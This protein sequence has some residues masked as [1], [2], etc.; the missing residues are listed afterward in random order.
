MMHR[1]KKTEKGRGRS[2]FKPG[3][4]IFGARSIASPDAEQQKQAGLCGPLCSLNLMDLPVQTKSEPNRTG[5]PDQLKAGI[6][7]LSGMDISD[8]RVH[9]NSDKPERLNALAYAQGSDIHL[10][11]G[12]GQH[13]PHEAW[14]LVQQRQGRVKPTLQAKGVEINDDPELEQ[15]ADRMGTKVGSWMPRGTMKLKEGPIFWPCEMRSPYGA[16]IRDYSIRSNHS[17]LQCN[18]TTFVFD[19][20]TYDL[21]KYQDRQK[22]LNNASRGMLKALDREIG[23]LRQGPQKGKLRA[24]R[25]E[26]LKKITPSRPRR[27]TQM[28]PAFHF[29]PPT[30]SGAVSY[31][32]NEKFRSTSTGASPLSVLRDKVR[33]EVLEPQL[34]KA[35]TAISDSENSFFLGLAQKREASGGNSMV[36]STQD[37]SGRTVQTIGFFDTDTART[38][39]NATPDA[40]GLTVGDDRG[41]GFPQYAV[42]NSEAADQ[43]KHMTA[44]NFLA[45]QGTTREVEELGVRLSRD[46]PKREV[47]KQRIYIYPLGDLRPAGYYERILQR[48]QSL[49]H[50]QQLLALLQSNPKVDRDGT[51]L[52]PAPDEATMRKML[53]DQLKPK[54]KTS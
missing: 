16:S 41:H 8:V 5:M 27:A 31:V 18:G 3:E 52:E 7:S 34:L 13:L 10:A 38:G 45:N 23:K 40:P 6:E 14:H 44:E 35:P 24:I 37:E 26:V 54:S 11:P 1:A 22:I 50:F 53:D 28:G 29:D 12:Q 9:A 51:L 36:V 4:S 2:A 49:S 30:S 20:H 39:R 43:V 21:S 42:V 15:E 25:L 19:G 17:P 47:I 46:D 33:S 48:T 32:A